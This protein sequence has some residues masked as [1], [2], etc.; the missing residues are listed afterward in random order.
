MNQEIKPETKQLLEA[1]ILGLH[2]L[3]STSSSTFKIILSKL[4]SLSVPNEG[5]LCAQIYL[6]EFVKK[7]APAKVPELFAKYMPV[8]AS[9]KYPLRNRILAI[10]LLV[11]ISLISG[12]ENAKT[13]LDAIQ[14]VLIAVDDFKSLESIYSSI[15]RAL[16]NSDVKHGI[17]K[18]LTAKA[19][20]YLRSK[21]PD[22]RRHAM[23]MFKA[24]HVHWQIDES[25]GF[26]FRLLADPN[27]EIRES[28][29]T[30]TVLYNLTDLD[31]LH[32][33]TLPQS[34]LYEATL[35]FG[36]LPIMA[37]AGA[38]LSGNIETTVISIHVDSSN[39]TVF[40]RPMEY[41]LFTIL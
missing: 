35:R 33:M 26:L 9:N 20:I 31:L 3:S 39:F 40:D 16:S 2:S 6:F 32:G 22:H 15:S 19:K 21:D 18:H 30:S 11:E 13:I 12:T 27:K 29:R 1:C 4:L 28:M 14:D 38:T 8:V 24:F 25:M 17:L 7:H 10:Q 34:A 5:D 37:N 41:W 36:K 23:V